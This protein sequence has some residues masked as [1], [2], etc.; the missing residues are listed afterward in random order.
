MNPSNRGE[1]GEALECGSHAAALGGG[2]KSGGCGHRTPKTLRVKEPFKQVHPCPNGASS[3]FPASNDTGGVIACFK[4]GGE[5]KNGWPRLCRPTP[6]AVPAQ[7]DKDPGD[8]PHVT[9]SSS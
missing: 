9:P 5:E 7:D 2:T 4:A 1:S 3:R 6:P 8:S